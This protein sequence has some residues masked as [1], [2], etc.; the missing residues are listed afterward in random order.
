MAGCKH[1]LMRKIVS[2][3]GDFAGGLLW[4][5]SPPFIKCLERY[6]WNIRFSH[7]TIECEIMQ[8]PHRGEDEVWQREV[9]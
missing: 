7:G 5:S 1:G 8:F 6:E 9:G 2:K 3:Y 4:I